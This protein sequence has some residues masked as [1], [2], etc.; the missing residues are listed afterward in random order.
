MKIGIFDSGI[1]GLTV[2]KYTKML[3]PNEEYYYYADT[4][5]VPY[6]NKTKEQI[7]EYS[8][9]AVSF[10]LDKG[11]DLVCIACNTA[12][13]VAADIL[14]QKYDKP[15]VGIE[16]AV[17]PAIEGTKD[18]R[19]LV[20]ATPVTVKEKKLKDLVDRLDNEHLVDVKGL[21]KLPLFAEKG[22][23]N[24]DDLRLYLNDE[25]EHLELNK[26]SQVVLGCTHFI[27]FKEILSDYFNR[28][29]VFLDGCQGTARNIN[30]ICKR[31]NY[32]TS[33][34]YA[35][36][37]YKSGKEVADAESLEFLNMILNRIN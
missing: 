23:F 30:R 33:D 18:G 8:D 31:E 1:G 9:K 3:M 19:I 16:P 37:F 20:L 11:C 21:E 17:K 13:S 26:Y 14:R 24:S 29:T 12:T 32:K 10:L 28:D 35:I 7:L 5:H 25:L 36:Y 15:I 2:L 34:S 4:A 22:D 27:H 6:G